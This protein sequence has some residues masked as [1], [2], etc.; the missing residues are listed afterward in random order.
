MTTLSCCQTKFFG[1]SS[2]FH[3]VANAR[4]YTFAAGLTCRRPSM[5][6]ALYTSSVKISLPRPT[7]SLLEMIAICNDL[8]SVRSG[9]SPFLILGAHRTGSCYSSTKDMEFVDSMGTKFVS[10]FMSP[11]LAWERFAIICFPEPCLIILEERRYTS[12]QQ[13]RT[14][15][16]SALAEAVD[17]HLSAC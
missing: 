7:H 8:S 17:S 6:T 15:F 2:A 1:A 10:I 3:F 4:W 9:A 12:F 11:A 13:R 14:V 16:H 5:V